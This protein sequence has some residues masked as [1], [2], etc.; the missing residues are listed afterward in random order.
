MYACCKVSIVFLKLVI[1][2]RMDKLVKS[3]LDIECFF[4]FRELQRLLVLYWKRVSN[5]YKKYWAFTVSFWRWIWTVLKRNFECTRLSCLLVTLLVHFSQYTLIN[6]CWLIF[7]IERLQHK[8]RICYLLW[9]Q[10]GYRNRLAPKLS[11]L[12]PTFLH[13][14]LTDCGW[15]KTQLHRRSNRSFPLASILDNIKQVFVKNTYL[16]K[17]PFNIVLPMTSWYFQKSLTLLP[18]HGVI[19]VIFGFPHPSYMT[20]PS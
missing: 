8:R 5:V 14:S 11:S 13:L 6:F 3:I 9:I 7:W 1:H 15:R 12:Q 18:N 19:S 20:Y 17:I 10:V 16:S 2:H 4:F